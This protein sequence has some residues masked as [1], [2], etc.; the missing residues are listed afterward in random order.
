VVDTGNRRVQSFS[1]ADHSYVSQF[2]YAASDTLSGIDVD[3]ANGQLLVADWRNSVVKRFSAAGAD[4]MTYG[5]GGG[6]GDGQL[7][8][9]YGV[10]VGPGGQVRGGG[11]AGGVQ[12]AAR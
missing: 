12:E 6:A 8:N 10:A 1:L 11:A 4:R 5:T 3:P 9:P 7:Q 2:A